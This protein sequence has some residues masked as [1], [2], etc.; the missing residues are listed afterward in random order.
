MGSTGWCRVCVLCGALIGAA[1][2]VGCGD[3]GGASTDGAGQRGSHELHG[4][5]RRTTPATLRGGGTS[6]DSQGGRLIGEKA[7]R[8]MNPLQAA[9]HFRASARAAGAQ[10]RFLE[11]V[12]F[13]SPRVRASPAYPKLVASLY[14]TTVPARDRAAA[15]AGC[16]DE[17]AASSPGGGAAPGRAQQE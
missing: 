5:D 2:M 13:P 4:S 3:G 11:L 9:R 7:C 8:G 1:L 12:A 10:A 15:A 6:D 14:A 17:L 16:A